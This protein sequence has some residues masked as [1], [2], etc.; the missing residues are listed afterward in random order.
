MLKA[1]EIKRAMDFDEDYI[2]K[3]NGKKQIKQLGNAVNPP[4]MEMIAE[5]IIATL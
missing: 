1:H 4:V 3:G 5:R 2:I